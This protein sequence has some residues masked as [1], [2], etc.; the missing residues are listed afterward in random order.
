MVFN[1]LI[2]LFAFLPL[3]LV[4]HYFIPNERLKNLVLLVLSLLFYTWGEFEGVLLLLT[5]IGFNYAWAWLISQNKHKAKPFLVTGV[6]VNLLLIIYFKYWHFLYYQFVPPPPY[7]QLMAKSIPLGISFFTFQSIA[8]LFDVYRGHLKAEKNVLNYALYISFFPQLIAGPI[9]RFQQISE[10]LKERIVSFEG[11]AEGFERFIIGLGKKVVIANTFAVAVDLV[12]E[13]PAANLSTPVMWGAALLY[14][15]QI[16]FDFSG[17]TDMAIG[18]GKMFGFNL[19]E[20]FDKPYTAKS[21]RQFWRR[22]HITLSTWFRD[23]L[24]IPLGGNQ[25]GTMRTY[26]NLFLVFFLCGLWHGASFTFIIWGMF[27]GIVMLAERGWWGRFAHQLP[28]FIQWAICFL[29]LVLS[30]VIFRAESLSQL[31]A[32]YSGMFS[33]QSFS[34]VPLSYIFDYK[35]CVLIAASIFICL[36]K[37][38]F[39]LNKNVELV[40]LGIKYIGLLLVLVYAVTLI[41]FQESTPFIYFRF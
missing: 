20:N 33:Y 17:Y 30:W 10:Q 39:K 28:N 3:A 6:V 27:H 36:P 23:Y 1:S 4:G 31:V 2:F 21:L 16:Y 34:V 41:M 15:F 12:F 35:N 22:W 8:Y 40:G 25:H 9:V 7:Y 18:L 38:S 37:F 29:L 32:W 5:S 26:L 11:L 24:Y 13:T 14:T 19:P